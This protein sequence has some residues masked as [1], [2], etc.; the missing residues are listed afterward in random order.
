MPQSLERTHQRYT[1][2]LVDSRPSQLRALAAYNPAIT[3]MNE[4]TRSCYRGT[5][6]ETI[7][8][9]PPVNAYDS[10]SVEH[11]DCRPT[12]G[13]IL[14]TSPGRN[15]DIRFAD[16]PATSEHS[17]HTVGISRENCTKRGHHGP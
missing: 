9:S 10:P 17:D 11:L 8:I 16:I 2:V 13:D 5:G 4:V 15:G 7:A 12:C 3:S 6:E 1:G 14:V